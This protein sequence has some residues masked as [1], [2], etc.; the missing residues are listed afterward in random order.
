M[1]S[2][3]RHFEQKKKTNLRQN[4]FFMELSRFLEVA[5]F[6]FLANFRFFIVCV[7]VWSLSSIDI[8]SCQKF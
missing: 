8:E 3:S 5:K 4:I 1:Y 6:R 2:K 7:M